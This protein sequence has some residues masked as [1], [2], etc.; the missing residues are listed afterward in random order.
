MKKEYKFEVKEKMALNRRKYCKCG[1]H[2]FNV[3]HQ[4]EPFALYDWWV[5]C[6]EC[7]REGAHGASRNLALWYWKHEYFDDEFPS[8]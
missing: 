5:E 8:I 1:S 7:G 2:I 4:L 6:P 3:I